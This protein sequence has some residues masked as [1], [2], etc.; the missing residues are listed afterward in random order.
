MLSKN[1]TLEIEAKF[2][3]VKPIHFSTR[4]NLNNNHDIVLS[5]NAEKNSE[6]MSG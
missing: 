6:N 2:I 4:S 5:P 1:Y 3:I